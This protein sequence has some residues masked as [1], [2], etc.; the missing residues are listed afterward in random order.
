MEIESVI[1]DVGIINSRDAISFNSFDHKDTTLIFSLDINSE[2]LD[3]KSNDFI[4]YTII[5]NDVIL[6]E[7][8]GLDFYDLSLLQSFF[9]IIKNSKLI[10]ELKHLGNNK[11]TNEHRRY[12]L[13]TYDYIYEIISS[14][15]ILKTN[16]VKH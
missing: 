16:L 1:T 11:I 2:L 4:K 9:D 10:E 13:A 14:K 6:Y 8:Y 3:V 15:Y 12:R 7:C 5:F